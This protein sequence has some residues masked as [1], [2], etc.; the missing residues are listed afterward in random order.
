MRVGI[1]GIGDICKK[2]Y[3]PITTSRDD[4]ELVLCTRNQDTMTEMKN[5][6]KIVESTKSIDELITMN[7]DCAFVHS[8]TESHYEI[9]KKLLE[10]DIHVYVDKPV[11]YKLEE[12]LELAKLAKDKNKILMVGFNR[13]HAPMVHDLKSLGTA[14]IIIIEKNRVNQP[15]VPR[16]FVYDDFI[17]VLDTLRFLMNDHYTDLT[18]DFHKDETGLKNIVVKLSNGRT[19]AIG[20]MNRDN[21]ITEETIEYMASGRKRTIKGLVQT[22]SFENNSTSIKEFGDWENTLTKRG[23]YSVIDTFITRV[24][25]ND[26]SPNLM[27][28]WIETHKLCEEVVTKIGF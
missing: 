13:R 24:K 23:F 8:S 7:I 25:N 19:T 26:I 20:L 28:D 2:A 27:E 6:Y 1:I 17:H 21:G 18:V 22:T 5:K 10:N 14:D 3:M 4:I 16:V 15:G 12:A 9:C 11:S